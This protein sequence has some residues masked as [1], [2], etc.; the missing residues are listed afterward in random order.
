MTN[1]TPN[2]NAFE[3]ALR[4]YYEDTDAG[5]VVYHANYLRYMERARNEWLRALGRTTK[6]VA[7]LDH[8]L[9]VVRR[10][11]LDF[12]APARLDD[13][14]IMTVSIEKLRHASMVLNQS[15]RV[16]DQQCMLATIV[17]AIVDIDTFKPTA[18]PAALKSVV[19]ELL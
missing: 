18:I 13:E 8:C 11:E 2:R 12:R 1:N 17:L 6:Q 19:N 4:I 14:L 3:W 15:A 7:D 10:C 16:G 5:G 9:F